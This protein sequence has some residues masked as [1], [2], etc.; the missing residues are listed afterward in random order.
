MGSKVFEE[1]LNVFICVA[2]SLILAVATGGL[3]KKSLMTGHQKYS[4]IVVG[5]VTWLNYNKSLDYI[6]I[7]SVLF[8]FV[9][10]LLVLTKISGVVRVSLVTQ[11]NEKFTRNYKL[12]LF[13]GMYALALGIFS[14]GY[15]K[16]YL[17]S[18]VVLVIVTEW[19]VR[20]TH[21][22]IDGHSFYMILIFA[23]FGVVGISTILYFLNP[24]IQM[25]RFNYVP[26][27]VSL[28][29]WAMGIG[30]L[31]FKGNFRRFRN[32]VL[33]TAQLLIPFVLLI[34]VSN[35]YS[36]NNRVIKL[37]NVK[38]ASLMVV[39]ICCIVVYNIFIW[40]RSAR[41]DDW[42]KV[43]S[44]PSLAAIAA[45]LLYNA[46]VVS[47]LAYDD[48][49]MGEIF[50]P[51]QQF[52]SFGLKYNVDFISVQGL[53]GVFYSSINHLIFD[54]TIASFNYSLILLPALL[55]A[56]FSI[57][58]TKLYGKK[59]AVYYI[60]FYTP[61]IF[62]PVVSRFYMAFP[63]IL[64]LF[65]PVFQKYKYKWL[66]AWIWLSAFHCF[67]NTTSGTALTLA[68]VPVAVL[69]L[70]DMIKSGYFADTFRKKRTLFISI[71]GGHLILLVLMYPSIVGTIRFLLDNSSSNTQAYGVSFFADFQAAPSWFPQWLSGAARRLVWESVRMGGWIGTFTIFVALLINFVKIKK[72]NVNHVNKKLFLFTILIF[73]LLTIPYSFGRIDPQ[74]MSR[75]GSMTFLCL[76]GVWPFWIFVKSQMRLKLKYLLIAAVSLGL[77]SCFI[78]GDY[79]S[80]IK[81]Y[82]HPHTVPANYQL[83]DGNQI[84]ME[85]VGMIFADSNRIN[86]WQTIRSIMNDLLVSP[87]ESFADL[88]NRSLLFA[89]LNR[90]VL[91][92]YSAD[93]VAANASIQD[94]VIDKL[95]LSRP[96]VVLLGPSIR[97]DGGPSSLRSYRLY[98]WFLQNDYLY[99]ERDHIQF[100]VRKDRF[101]Q[102]NLPRL[103]EQT[104][105]DKL[106]DIFLTKDM[107]YVPAS[108]G[109]SFQNMQNR[110]QRVETSPKLIQV[111]ETSNDEQGWMHI[112]GLDPYYVWQLPELAGKDADFALVTIQMQQ[113]QDKD[114]RIQTYFDYKGE[115]NQR[116]N[117]FFNG[118]NQLEQQYLIPLGSAPSWLLGHITYFR[119]DLDGMGQAFKIKEPVFYKLVR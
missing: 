23:F 56:G 36:F 10:Y 16:A 2:I 114:Y 11:I 14:V 73:I 115:L 80:Y 89:A 87:D 86:E 52:I 79:S 66:L 24:N 54:G 1:K 90:K 43:I 93:Y 57:I 51:W 18:L 26:S 97:H 107:L 100:L 20:R 102:L 40:I 88:S 15:S 30:V 118:T 33:L 116:D 32:G 29:L 13:V 103:D 62:S 94:K 39:L 58:I 60:L 6:F 65:N 46:P 82:L 98:R 85:A 109:S 7:F 50:L 67:Y 108:W 49:H 76:A 69:K 21:T 48:F 92:L 27:L 119:L 34:Y 112:N 12:V 41:A 55:A 78:T 106:S 84:G 37:V 28:L 59:R 45:A 35:Y 77:S 22:A 19:I 70:Y 101:E 31:L 9:I 42:R 110:F 4:D 105:F 63:I 38:A 68:T 91:T 61:L 3:L 113:K 72:T 74:S 104:E 25:S 81:N 64:I 17:L 8:S 47:T 96:P 83:V 111:H 5:S 75:S 95:E 53:L 117:F 71:V 99:Y 44:W